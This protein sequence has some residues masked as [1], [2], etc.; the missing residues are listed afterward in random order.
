LRVLVVDDNA[1]AAEGFQ[2][3]LIFMDIGMPRRNGYEAAE[4]LVQNVQKRPV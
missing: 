3:H 1:A 4:R 2:P